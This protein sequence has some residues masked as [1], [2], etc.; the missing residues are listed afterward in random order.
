[1]AA[2]RYVAADAGGAASKTGAALRRGSTALGALG[3]DGG[4]GGG[5]GG[6]GGGGG[7]GSGG[8][9]GG[10]EAGGEGHR[11]GSLFRRGVLPSFGMRK[12]S[13]TRAQQPWVSLAHVTAE[14]AKRLTRVNAKAREDEL[15]PLTIAARELGFDGR[16]TPH[17]AAVSETAAVTERLKALYLR[18]ADASEKN[19]EALAQV[20]AVVDEL[21]A[22]NEAFG[23]ALAR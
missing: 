23:L 9:G 19:M 2:L 22:E 10:G 12:G 16:R 20:R 13:L 4:G 7:G 1:M 18:E 11:R 14:E 3:E 17:Q 15:N 5:G 21:R 8:S 6:S